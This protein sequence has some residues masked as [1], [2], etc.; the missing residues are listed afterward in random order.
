MY[1]KK[2][3]DVKKFRKTFNTRIIRAKQTY[4]TD[5]VAT[6]LKVHISTIHAWYKSGLTRIDR[7]QPH[8]VFGQDLID[9]LNLRNKQKKRPCK[10]EEL[11][12]CKCQK[13]SGPLDNILCIKI[14]KARANLV[15]LCKACGAKIN[16]AIS[17]FRI[18][19]FK[20]IFT[21]QAVHEENLIECAN[22]CA[23]TNKKQ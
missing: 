13:P 14:T 10:P 16:K 2:K 1:K 23:I 11:F 7:D 19:D 17:P 15:G 20:K 5:E 21:V 18:D 6:L 22:T 3:K 4:S 9:F 12:C 8:L